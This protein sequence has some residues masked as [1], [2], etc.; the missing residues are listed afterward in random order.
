MAEPVNTSDGMIQ[1]KVICTIEVLRSDLS[2]K[3]PGGLGEEILDMFDD[4]FKADREDGSDH[5][6]GLVDCE[7]FDPGT[8]RAEK[9]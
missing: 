7:I 4:V 9:P 5:Y 3:H 2:G 1:V 8:D 6:L